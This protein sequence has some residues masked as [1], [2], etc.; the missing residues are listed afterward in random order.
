MP[1]LPVFCGKDCGGNACPLLATIENGRVSRITNN[2]AGG[3]YLKGCWRGLN[4]SLETY[5][6]DRILQP[7]VRSGPRG[8]GQFRPASWDE[9]LDLT[10]DRLAEIRAQYGPTAVMNSAS[11]GSTS[12][13][14]ASW[15]LL[16]RFL[17]YFG[18]YTDRVGG[19]SNAAA[20]SVLPYLLGEGWTNSGFDAS[21]MQSAG[22]IILWGANVLET[23]QGAEVP[24]RLLEAKRRGAQVVVIDPRRSATVKRAATWWIPCRPGTD[25]ALMLSVLYVLLRE[26]LVDRPF[27]Q[28]HANGFER[29]ERYVLGEGGEP[30]S[31]QWAEAICGV[32]AEEITRFAHAY[33][34][35]KPAML[36]PGY[37]I[38]R[39][40]AGEEPFRLTVALQLATG[41]FGKRGGST[42]SMNSLLPSP[43]VGRLSG[44][45]IPGLPEVPTLRWPDAILLGREGGYPTDVHA[46]Y[47][48][49]ANL[50]NQGGDVHK[51]MAA[52]AKVDF[53][54]CHELF[55]TPTAR[56][57]DVILPA[58]SALER[59]DVGIPWLGN[60]LLYRPQ[61][62]APRGQAR[63]D[64]DILWDLSSRLGL[65]Q[66]FS[67]GRSVAEWV[68][69]FIEQS[70]ISDPEAFRRSGIYWAQRQERVGLADFAADP[71][72][73]PLAT[74]SGKV[75]IASQEYR[76]ATGFPGIPT[77][78]APPEDR[79][80]PL[81]LITPKSPYRTHSQGSNIAEVRRR[82][83]H[84][85]EMNPRDA[86]ERGIADGDSVSLFNER[87]MARI[88]V[89]LSEDIIP[90]VVC[91]PEGVWV[92]LDE[93]GIERAGSA[94]LFTS[95]EGTRP[96]RAC[97]MHGVGVQVRL[98]PV[99]SYSA[100]GDEPYRL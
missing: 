98:E 2:P 55:L 94:N 53:V 69:L 26:Q 45:E 21:T 47:S 20:G 99:S 39:V 46:I 30:R 52:L 75:E 18:G 6:P 15:A 74:P 9:A 14:H 33:A 70:E 34:A 4:L 60:Y 83:A 49:G 63:D 64:Y 10:A 91:L 1:S 65:G 84:A 66:D 79:R 23:R 24:Q 58:T 38:Q 50:L 72:R 61:V 86:G 22:M 90:G 73:F 5:A 76:E 31:P 32:P 13:L 80:Y 87:G 29:L 43:R 78:Q 25:S 56:W 48:L 12:A 85:L 42:G 67:Q 7:L 17:G 88:S 100:T 81:R 54:V 77:W 8:S 35:A 92:E 27:I 59:E 36:L 19:Y 97:I 96:Q 28:A 93:H 89:R 62:L 95:T 82:A 16:H 71:E 3:R 11:A 51:G 57:S 37:S 40:Y 68:Q 44:P 41:N